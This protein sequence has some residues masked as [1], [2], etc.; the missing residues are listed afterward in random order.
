MEKGDLVMWNSKGSNDFG[1]IGLI[2]G[3]VGKSYFSDPEEVQYTV[4][5]SDGD[6]V[7]YSHIECVRRLDIITLEKERL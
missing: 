2:F 5:W 1:C 7:G 3:K 6:V 4:L